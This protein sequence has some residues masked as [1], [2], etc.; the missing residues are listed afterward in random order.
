MVTA[1]SQPGQ[2][3]ALGLL[4]TFG[5]T[6]AMV[7]LDAMEKAGQI[8]VLQLELNDML[9]VCVKIVGDVASVRAAIDR[10]HAIAEQMQGQP[11][12]HVIARPD[13]RPWKTIEAPEEYNPLI[14]QSVVTNPY[15][16]PTAD[17]PTSSRRQVMAEPVSALGFIETQGFTAV[18]EA[19][20]T[21]CKAANV[22]VVGKEKLGGGY[23][24]I[25]IK[26]DV[27]AVSAAIDA[28]KQRVEGLG[29]L[30]AAHVIPRPS[31]SVLSLLPK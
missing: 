5:F 28:G 6:P 4:E 22:E 11:V 2:P 10:G 12:S 15:S 29:K 18:F 14:Q 27:A 23:V 20:D 31:Q 9:G 25:V 24:T 16:T 17:N 3:A 8:R 30:I 19:I 26:G 1:R 13:S 7:A 21:A